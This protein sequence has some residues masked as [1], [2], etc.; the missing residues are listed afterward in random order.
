MTFVLSPIHGGRVSETLRSSMKN[1]SDNWE[2]LRR[3][4]LGLG[5]SS[6]HK[7]HYPSLR[8]RLAELERV[9]SKLQQ[10]EAYLLEAQRL[11]RTGSF[12]WN[13]AT[14]DHIWSEETFRIFQ[15]DTSTRITRQLVHERVHPEDRSK[16]QETLDRA[17]QERT[18][19][20]YEHRLLMP[21]GSVKY[22]H[23]VARALCDGCGSPELV[24]AVMDVTEQHHA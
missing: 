7:T 8:Q 21:D 6:V 15:Y 11:S 3:K 16:V 9:R 23:V 1:P 22:V 17:V 5:D 19:L 10:S 12:G 4:V 14:D 2:E 20:D 24:G 18:G 13:L